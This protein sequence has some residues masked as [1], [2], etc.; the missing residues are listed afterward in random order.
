MP[1]TPRQTIA[2]IGNPN[3]GKT[4]L[5]NALTGLRQRVANYPGVTVEQKLGELQIDGTA[6]NLVDL[7]GTYSL[8][9]ISPDEM[10]TVD[11]LLGQQAGAPQVKGILAIVDASNLPRNLYLVS[12]LIECSLPIVIALNMMDLALAKGVAVDAARLSERLGIPVIPT[13]AHR[14]TGIVEVRRALANLCNGRVPVDGPRF[15]ERVEGALQGL[16]RALASLALQLGRSIQRVEAERILIDTEG[17]AARRL[18]DKIP[19]FGVQLTAWRQQATENGSLAGLEAIIRYQWIRQVTDVAMT[20]MTSARKTVSDRIDAVLTHKIL[21]TGIFLAITAIVFQSI[22]TWAVPLQDGIDTVLGWMGKHVTSL[23]PAGALQ[24][25]IVDGLIKGVGSVLVFIP[26]IALLFCFIALLEDCGYMARAAFLM[27]RLLSRIGLSGKSFI[28]LLS[29]F[30]CAVPGIMAART[31]DNRRDRLATILAAP[32]MSCS[33]RLP[34]YTLLI[35]AF[36]PPTAYLGG[37]IDLRGLTLFAMHLVGIC[38]A[39]PVIW[40]LKCSVLRGQ[41]APFVMELP[42]YKRPSLRLVAFRVYDRVHAFVR[43]AGTIIAAMTIVI[44]ALAY[45]PHEATQ[46]HAIDSSAL[47][48]IGRFAEPAFAPLGWDWRIA[49]AAIAAFPAREVVVAAFGTIFHVG[50]EVSETSPG[51]R[52]ALQTATWPDGRALFTLPVA[53]SLM[54]FFALC[55]QCGATVATIRRETNSWG[56]AWFTFGYMTALAYAGAFAVYHIAIALGG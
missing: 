56:W 49:M 39:I 43:R 9:A 17:L 22:Y 29:S 7:P 1:V 6:V 53:L 54:V 55:C 27:D 48:R 47:G 16:Q 14:G 12:Q 30:A 35:A 24:S 41:P 37:W 42:S 25:L 40:G 18:I 8:A 4:T 26:Q 3:T 44:W 33:A 52:A 13:C 2:L 46:A 5:F 34:V 36:I 45:F 31:I 38:V 11:T 23:L 28:P 21:G 19:A 50:A 32:L 10:I 20:Q 51:L 15:P